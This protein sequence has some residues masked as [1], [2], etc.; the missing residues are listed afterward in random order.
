MDTP[1]PTG[2]GVGSPDSE[3]SCGADR[4]YKDGD[5]EPLGGKPQ[6][7]YGLMNGIYWMMTLR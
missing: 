3:V 2:R 6:E 7:N 4:P 1:E 5:I